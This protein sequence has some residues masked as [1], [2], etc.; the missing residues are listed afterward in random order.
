MCLR[1]QFC[2]YRSNVCG[3]LVVSY[4][5]NCARMHE[6]LR[7]LGYFHTSLKKRASGYT[8]F[9]GGTMFDVQMCKRSPD[10]FE[11]K[12]NRSVG[13]EDIGAVWQKTCVSLHIFE[14]RT[15]RWIVCWIRYRPQ[16]HRP[17]KSTMFTVLSMVLYGQEHWLARLLNN[18]NWPPVG[19][20]ILQEFFSGCCD[21][22]FTFISWWHT[23]VTYVNAYNQS[24]ANQSEHMQSWGNKVSQSEVLRLW[25]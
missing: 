12:R 18:W 25:G 22:L 9:W 17:R 24:N 8:T 23:P 1:A 5:W 14:T 2:S 11:L 13:S 10:E 6:P 15:S 3:I 21:A 4:R 16:R 20:Q 19:N 7:V